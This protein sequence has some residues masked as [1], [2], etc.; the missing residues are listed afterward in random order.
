MITGSEAIFLLRYTTG[1]FYAGSI[2]A[3]VAAA[4][5]HKSLMNNVLY[6][7]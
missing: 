4:M 2:S 5:L 3:A 1:R 7:M 6:K